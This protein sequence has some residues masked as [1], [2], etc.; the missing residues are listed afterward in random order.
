MVVRVDKN[1]TV[2]VER[3]RGRQEESKREGGRGVMGI[4]RYKL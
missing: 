3:K 2:E 1:E 4:V